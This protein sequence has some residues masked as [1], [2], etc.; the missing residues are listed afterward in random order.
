M[1]LYSKVR[2]VILDVLSDNNWHTA[3]ELQST[4][5]QN[6]IE[7]KDGRGPIYNVIH[8]LKAENEV[9]G[10]GFGRYKRKSNYTE[11]AS[12]FT[13]KSDANYNELDAALKTIRIALAKYQKFDWIKCSDES[14]QEARNE[15]AKIIN[16]STEIQ[17]SFKY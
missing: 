13:K 14:L 2:K 7:F 8:T 10:D 17:D 6:G 5:E 11:N 3:D 16:L 15:V 4:C 1:K 12:N 9:E